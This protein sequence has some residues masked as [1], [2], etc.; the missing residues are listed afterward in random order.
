MKNTTMRILIVEQEAQVRSALRLLV[1]QELGVTVV[2]TACDAEEALEL[3][4]E[5]RPHLVLL[6][7]ELP[8][9]SKVALARLRRARAS[10]LVIALSRR[11]DARQAALAQGADVFVSKTDPP[12]VLQEALRHPVRE[13]IG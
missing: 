10:L 4:V 11:P 13:Q 2:G 7:W 9:E 5:K 12:E 6:D 3:V 1:T 8:C